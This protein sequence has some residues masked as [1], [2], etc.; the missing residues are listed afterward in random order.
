MSG[1]PFEIQK[2]YQSHVLSWSW[3]WGWG[4]RKREGRESVP[5]HHRAREGVTAVALPT[6]VTHCQWETLEQ[7]RDWK[8]LRESP[9]LPPSP[10]PPQ[11]P[12]QSERSGIRGRAEGSDPTGWAGD[13]GGRSVGRHTAA[14]GGGRLLTL[15]A[16]HE[17]LL[18]LHVLLSCLL[19]AKES[20]QSDRRASRRDLPPPHP[21]KQNKHFW[22]QRNCKS[23]NLFPSRTSEVHIC[24]TLLCFISDRLLCPIFR[25]ANY[26][27]LTQNKTIS[28]YL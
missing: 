6:A 23:L 5:A 18:M 3:G 7:E 25:F 24:I 2:L 1:G 8:R 9:P 16:I 20:M 12:V 14:R 17:A 27:N 28:V 19:Y 13:G 15:S 22:I 4:R 10:T 26:Q 11:L 21:Q